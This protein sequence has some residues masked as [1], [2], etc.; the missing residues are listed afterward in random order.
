MTEIN[1]LSRHPDA[2]AREAQWYKKFGKHKEQG[3]PTF[4][5]PNVPEGGGNPI[6]KRCTCPNPRG[7]GTSISDHHSCAG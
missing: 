7:R 6:D 1:E 5:K 4:R 3:V 2:D